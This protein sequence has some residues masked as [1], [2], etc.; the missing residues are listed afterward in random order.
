MSSDIP[1]RMH[2]PFFPTPRGLRGG[3][4]R[5]CTRKS[6]QQAG[7][8]GSWMIYSAPVCNSG[9][10]GAREHYSPRLIP[11][12]CSDLRWIAVGWIGWTC[13]GWMG[14][15]FAFF[16]FFS[17]GNALTNWVFETS[18]SFHS[19]RVCRRGAWCGDWVL[20]ER[21]NE[22]FLMFG[23]I[24]MDVGNGVCLGVWHVV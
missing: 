19:D 7:S 16:F 15:F 24:W 5:D 2:H 1:V 3:R 13:S 9:H 18:V 21:V 22:L 11:Y 6:F 20:F 8:R 12:R 14:F 4:N 10:N 23:Y 17:T